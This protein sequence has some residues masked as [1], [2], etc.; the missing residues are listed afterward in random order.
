MRAL[1]VE[2]ERKCHNNI[3]VLFDL[4]ILLKQ[5]LTPSN[6]SAYSVLCDCRVTD[7]RTTGYPTNGQA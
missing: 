4:K 5:P 7:N 3:G 2:L 1:F 6:A